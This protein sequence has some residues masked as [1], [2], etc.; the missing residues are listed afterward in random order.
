MKLKVLSAPEVAYLLRR[1]LGPTRN[2]DDTLADMRRGKVEVHGCILLPNCMGKHAHAWRPMY[3]APDI[4]A[5]I[6]AVRAA[7]PC[8]T[9][10]VPYQVKTVHADPTDT[11]PWYTRKLLV[12]RSTFAPMMGG[13]ARTPGH[14][15]V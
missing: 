4:L 3:A 14:M 15:P 2:W 8:A 12:A 6:A 1:E 13:S 5:F 7:D 11:R 10:N 9:R